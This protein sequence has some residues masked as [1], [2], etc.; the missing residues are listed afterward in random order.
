MAEYRPAL[1]FSTPAYL[2]KPVWETVK[3]V[4]KKTFPEPTDDDLFFCSFK[5]YGGTEALNNGVLSVEDTATVETWYAPEFAADCAVMLAGNREIYEILGSPE[6]I[7]MRNQFVK[8][9]VRHLKG[10]A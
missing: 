10:G 8:F 4:R 7:N 3:G 2:L 9:K 5:T 1:P 6:N